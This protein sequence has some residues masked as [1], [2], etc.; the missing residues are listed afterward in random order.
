[1]IKDIP[2]YDML[3]PDDEETAVY[4]TALVKNP[5]IEV[6][7]VYLSQ[8]GK[9]IQVNL[10]LDEE[11]RMIYTPVLIPKQEIFREDIK[12]EPYK[13]RFSAEV[14]EKVSQAYIKSGNLVRNF[15]KEHTEESLEGVSVVENWIIDDEEQ[16]KSVALGFNLP[17]GTWMQ[18]IKI[19]SDSIWEQV[20]NGTYKG[21]SIE[22]KFI[23]QL[24]EMSE[25]IEV[26]EKETENEINDKLKPE[27]NTQYLNH[28]KNKNGL[29]STLLGAIATIRGIKLG[30]VELLD[31]S[32]M[33][34]FEGDDLT[35]GLNV[36]ADEA[37]EVPV[38]DGT[39]ELA[40]GRILE[41]SGGAVASLR[42]AEAAAEESEGEEVAESLT[43]D[44]I[45]AVLESLGKVNE[46]LENLEKSNVNVEDLSKELEE[47]K[48]ELSEMKE[49]PA[50]KSV[51]TLSTEED[52][53]NLARFRKNR[54]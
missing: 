39:Y 50:V 22:G 41:V 12:G 7:F 1:M 38:A 47:T 3:F 19:E 27:L 13:I 4:A 8:D 46:R 36:F 10:K 20:K 11:K 32:A 5:A 18:G 33:M 17:V 6:G 40:D 14:I 2:L 42:V 45:D 26:E 48:T 43:K 24:V 49:T 31:G 52:N 54:I 34:H 29:V 28:M 23:D 44:F 30:S 16:D 37:M 35:D 21:I 25:Q 53:S 9:E 15:N 51:Q